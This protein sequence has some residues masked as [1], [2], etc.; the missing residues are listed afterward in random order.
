MQLERLLPGEHNVT[1]YESDE[2]LLEELVQFAGEGLLTGETVLIIATTAHTEALR[3][4]LCAVAIDPVRAEHD[5]D[6]RFANAHTLLAAILRGDEP[7][8]D[9]FLDHVGP[10]VRAALSRG[11]GRVRVFG[12]IVNLL[13]QAGRHPAA[14]AIEDLWRELIG[15]T[16][17]VLLCAYRMD[18][19]YQERLLPRFRALCDKHDHS[20][21]I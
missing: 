7:S 21:R 12:E 18:D 2:A 19:I 3:E 17:I 1:F 6:L 5:G 11:N 10:H 13:W 16:G 14:L 4:A 8:R 20:A 9:Q 15:Q